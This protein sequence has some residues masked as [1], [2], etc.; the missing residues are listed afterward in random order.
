MVTRKIRMSPAQLSIGSGGTGSPANSG[1]PGSSAR[2]T[3]RAGDSEAG[4]PCDI[5]HD[6]DVR[7]HRGAQR[8]HG[9]A[10]LIDGAAG[11]D[12]MA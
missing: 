8:L 11:R 7:A 2:R 1:R 10:D 12:V 4:R 3:H 6:G 9:V 5:H